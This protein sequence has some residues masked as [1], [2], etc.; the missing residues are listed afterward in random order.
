MGQ[1]VLQ[2][3]VFS[4]S[5]DLRPGDHLKTGRNRSAPQ[6]LE[7]RERGL[8]GAV[9]AHGVEEELQRVAALHDAGPSCGEQVGG[10]NGMPEGEVMTWLDYLREI[11]ETRD[12]GRLVVTLKE[13]VP[14]YSPSTHVLK[15]VIEIRGRGS[16]AAAD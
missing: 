3:M 15:R 6:R 13:T 4:V 11:C 7:E 14:D 1:I 10:G 16:A 2:F 5:R 8:T 12:A 9:A